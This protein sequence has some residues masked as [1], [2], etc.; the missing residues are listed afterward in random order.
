VAALLLALL[1][2]AQPAPPAHTVEVWTIGPGG[3]FYDIFGHNALVL[4]DATGSYAFDWGRFSFDD[5]PRFIGD[6]ARAD[7]IYSMGV[8]PPDVVRSHYEQA[9]RDITVQVLHLTAEEYAALRFDLFTEAQPGNDTY[10]YDYFTSNCSTLLRDR[11]DSA[12]GGLLAEAM[13]DAPTNS[14]YRREVLRTAAN[15]PLLGGL[16]D[17]AMGRP[18][19]E[20]IDAWQQSFLPAQLAAHLR[21]LTRP[22]GSPLVVNEEIIFRGSRD[23][24]P[25]EPP[26]RV[27]PM[28]VLGV[29]IGGGTLALAR[30]RRTR[31]LGRALGVTWAIVAG[32]GGLGLGYLWLFSGHDHAYRNWSLLAFSPVF[33]VA[34]IALLKARRWPRFAKGTALVA[35]ASVVGAV[36][37]SLL[38]GQHNA[39]P[40]AR[41]VPAGLAVAWATWR[42][43]DWPKRAQLSES[44]P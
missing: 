22:D 11:L 38:A 8:A 27:L 31:W 3:T 20:P 30:L 36:I 9:D 15:T 1:L 28:A 23:L 32:V 42:A 29:L 37:A 17:A 18:C 44:N 26:N 41:S 34:A 13:I 40:L 33:L 21:T 10:R 2:A 4:T 7:L 5:L 6:F 14:S 24:T 25:P 19:D 12:T 43:T 16:L 35:A 39:A